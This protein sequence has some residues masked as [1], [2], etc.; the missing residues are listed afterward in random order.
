MPAARVTCHHGSALSYFG[1]A[2]NT[3]LYRLEHYHIRRND[4]RAGLQT[5]PL[6]IVVNEHMP[7]HEHM[8]PITLDT[9]LA[10][11]LHILSVCH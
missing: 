7:T 6:E 8:V 4:I 2:R 11:Q 3:S 10:C 9:A 5:Y 1:I